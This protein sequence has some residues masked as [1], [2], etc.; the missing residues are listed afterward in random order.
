MARKHTF[1]RILFAL[2]IIFTVLALSIPTGKPHPLLKRGLD[3]TIHTGMFVI[4]GVLGQAA[5]PWTGILLSAPLA[6]GTEFIQKFI[7]TGREYNIVDLLS[8]LIGL[9]LGILSCELANRLK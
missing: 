8:N 4:M 3:K 1:S 7:S 5:M 2:W 9:G 6:F